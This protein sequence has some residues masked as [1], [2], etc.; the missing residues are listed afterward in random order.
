MDGPPDPFD[1]EG[2][3]ATQFL[4]QHG[5]DLSQV[6]GF[7]TASG[8]VNW[9]VAG[10]VAESICLTNQDGDGTLDDPEVDPARAERLADLVRAA[11]TN[12]AAT[13]GLAESTALDVHCVNRRGWTTVTL[14]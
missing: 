8:P 10:Q 4:A 2:F 7:L 13:T 6:L 5:I 11:Q 3:D 12:V 14:D 9:E 1:P